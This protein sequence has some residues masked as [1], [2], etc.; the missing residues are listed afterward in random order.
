[1]SEA[2]APLHVDVDSGGE[3]DGDLSSP[4]SQASSGQ[5]HFEDK[6]DDLVMSTMTGNLSLT[7]ESVH[8]LM[9]ASE[10]LGGAGSK[11]EVRQDAWRTTRAPLH[12]LLRTQRER[13]RARAR[14]I[15]NP[16]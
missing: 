9:A 2:E 11:L 3:R 1:M 12:S 5:E 4:L 15:E 16:C 6:Y 13:A 7:H 14:A 10:T 8:A